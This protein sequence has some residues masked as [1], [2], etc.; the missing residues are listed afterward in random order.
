MH[1][2]SLQS[3]L[4]LCD[5]TD[6]SLSGSSVL[7][8]LQSRILEWVAMPSSRGS[9]QPRDRTY[10]FYVSGIGRQVLYHQYHLGS[11]NILVI[12]FKHTYFAC[13]WL[14]LAQNSSSNS[15]IKV[16]N[17]KTLFCFVFFRNLPIM[18]IE[19]TCFSAQIFRQTKIQNIFAC[20]EIQNILIVELEG[21]F[22][23]LI[24]CI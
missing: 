20:P 16:S 13:F 14:C 15:K 22:L 5:P 2:Q 10:I 19:G 1:A 8:I 24:I 11:P 12:S 4:T 6:C 17:L 23:Q 21:F 18:S 3:C 7:G 9:S